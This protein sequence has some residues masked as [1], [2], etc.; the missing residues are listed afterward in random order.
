MLMAL[1]IMISGPACLEKPKDTNIAREV[2][3]LMARTAAIRGLEPRGLVPCRFIGYEEYRDQIREEADEAD[4]RQDVALQQEVYVMLDLVSEDDDLWELLTESE[5][6]NVVGYYEYDSRTI[7][8]VSDHQ[9]LGDRERVLLAH[10]YAHALQDR[11]FDLDQLNEDV[12]YFTDGVMALESLIEGDATRLEREY[13][14][15]VLGIDDTTELFIHDEDYLELP[16][17][18]E[19]ISSFPYDEGADFVTA[20]G[21]WE[22][23]N[24][25]FLDPPLSTEQIIHP[26]KYI[27][28]IDEPVWLDTPWFDDYLGGHWELMW[29]D[30]MGELGYRLYLETY[31][32][33]REAV[34]AAAGWDGDYLEYWKED[35]GDRFLVMSSTWDDASEAAE[36]RRA[37]RT[38]MGGKSGGQWDLQLHNDGV[39]WWQGQGLTVYLEQDEAD[40]I[41][42][43]AYDL[44][45][46]EGILEAF[47]GAPPEWGKGAVIARTAG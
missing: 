23:V 28:E 18:F 14:A 25:A 39:S 26:E 2:M 32:P 36:F 19:K 27:D 4:Y 22:A 40:V 9:T 20:L 11:Y 6:G 24:R 15:T 29:D 1:V 45:V 5:A 43:M 17:F 7:F 41:I 44:T 30:V 12:G 37:F 46:I 33:S 38:F 21:D 3:G 13:A 35:G 34:S 42:V 10:E 16:P 47:G 31:V 8:M